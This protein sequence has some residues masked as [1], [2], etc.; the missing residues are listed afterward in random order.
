M[1]HPLN[2]NLFVKTSNVKKKTISL[3]QFKCKKN[4]IEITAKL[5]REQTPVFLCGEIA[6]CFILFT[7]PALDEHK[8][9]Q[10]HK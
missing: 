4:M 6:E 3:I 2:T 5:V 9:A 10:S 7:N 8:I 1:W